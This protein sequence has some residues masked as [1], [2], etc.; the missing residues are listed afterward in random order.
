MLDSSSDAVSAAY[1]PRI[2]HVRKARETNDY[3]QEATSADN[4]LY[5]IVKAFGFEG[6]IIAVA[7]PSCWNE[8]ERVVAAITRT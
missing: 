8:F 1:M 3:Q 2:D 7:S 5:D 6:M 4:S